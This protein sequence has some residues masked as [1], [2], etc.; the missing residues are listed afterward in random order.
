MGELMRRYWQPIGAVVEM[1][2]KWTRAVACS[3]E[4]LV[5]FA[6]A[7]A[8]RDSSPSS[9]RTGG[10]APHGI[11]TEEGIRCPYHGWEFMARGAA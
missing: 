2:G 11:P 9:A 5:S 3:G 7:R 1:E 6:I 4:N 8:A 10:L